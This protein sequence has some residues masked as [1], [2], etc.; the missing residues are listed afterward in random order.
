M[1]VLL[2][3]LF[4]P[5]AASAVETKVVIRVV[6]ADT[7]VIDGGQYVKL[8][9]IRAPDEQQ[10]ALATR[11]FLSSTLLGQE[12]SIE[13][14]GANAVFG[15]KDKYG[16]LLAYVYRLSDNLFVNGALIV[17]GL[18]FVDTTN[19]HKLR[20]G[21]L[22]YQQQA[23]KERR[24]IWQTTDYSPQELAEKNK[25]PL[26]EQPF[27]P[28][29]RD[30][31]PDLRLEIYWAKR[32][33]P[34]FRTARSAEEANFLASIYQEDVLKG[35]LPVMVQVRRNLAS[36]LNEHF[37][38]GGVQLKVEAVGEEAEILKF[39]AEG[40][41]QN[42]AEKFLAVPFNKELFSGLEFKEVIFTDGANFSYTYKVE[43]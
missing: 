31:T 6:S 34:R 35:T 25:V 43:H 9:G 24:G 23:R 20:T 17:H 28:N 33:D 12:V 10:Q 11:K 7:L 15:H 1:L 38:A 42:D 26:P 19:L 21:L 8:L 14:D 37:S 5:T 29:E 36:A 41:D 30:K 3:L 2:L 4:L 32:A 16:R 18:A 13:T 22:M 39:I 27:T 40:M